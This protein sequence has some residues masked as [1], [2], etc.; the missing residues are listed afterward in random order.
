[1]PEAISIPWNS[2]PAVYDEP[3]SI[4]TRVP[5]AR[6]SASV[7][8]IRRSAGTVGMSVSA[9]RVFS[10]LAGSS[11]ACGARAATTMP[12]VRSAST[13]DRAGTAGGARHPGGRLTMTPLRGQPRAADRHAGATGADGRRGG[14]G[15]SGLRAGRRN[16]D[17]ARRAEQEAQREGADGLEREGHRGRL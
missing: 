15:R 3:A 10:V 9:V 14:D 6:T 17:R 13:Q 16:A 5:S 8:T 1:M 12:D 2:W 4:P 11:R 7:A